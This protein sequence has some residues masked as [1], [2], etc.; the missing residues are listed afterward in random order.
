MIFTEQQIETLSP[1]PAAFNAGKAL[2]I[3][4]KWT[5]LAKNERVVWGEIQ[6]SG[7][8]PYQTQ[9]DLNSIAFKC[10]CPSRQ[11]PCKHNIGLMLLF[12]SKPN[13]FKLIDEEPEWVKSWINKRQTKASKPEPDDRTSEEQEKLD[14]SKEKTQI[15]RFSSVQAG[16][17]ELEL[18]LKDLIRIGILELPNKPTVEYS[19]IAARMV[20]AKAPGL[21]S[22]VRML[23]N[24]N[25]NNSNEWQSEAL[26]IISKLF[27][28][29]NTFKNYDN[30]TPLWQTTIK[31]L[32]GWNQSP[33]E[34]IASTETET[35]KDKWLVA[36]QITESNDDEITTQRNYLIGCES[37][38][39][40]LILYFATKFSSI[41][42][43]L[44]PG[45]I[46]NAELAF[47]PSVLPHRAVIKMTRSVENQLESQPSTLNSWQEVYEKKAE[48]QLRNPW[49]PETFVIIN[50]LRLTN[51]EN[52][53]VAYDNEHCCVRIDPKF[54]LQKIMK[55]LVISGNR[56]MRVACI[57]KNEEIIPLGIFEN[58]HYITL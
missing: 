16:V 50:D 43:P 56:K 24:L 13:E 26:T 29:I 32:V 14:K 28:L 30:L 4:S 20:D 15:E 27:L 58:N 53:W 23:G 36:G 52:R 47:F 31:N 48:Q 34:L 41:E 7:K 17:I 11:F 42:T 9:I 33:K 55:W 49:S 45:S 46:I 37:N 12:S 2:S 44:L 10:N 6:G 51:Q 22:W 8:K 35:V 3:I 19:R 5:T 18:W 54:E 39:S 1:N 40:A 25:F 38:R 57:L 21:A